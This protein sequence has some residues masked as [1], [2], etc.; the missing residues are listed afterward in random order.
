MVYNCVLRQWPADMFRGFHDGG[1]LMPTTVFVLVSAIQ[2][3][4]RVSS[5]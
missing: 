5:S 2:K 3:I 1:N 4:A